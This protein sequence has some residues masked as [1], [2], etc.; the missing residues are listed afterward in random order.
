MGRG[1][2]DWGFSERKYRFRIRIQL[3]TGLQYIL[4]FVLVG[5]ILN[6]NVQAQTPINSLF[7][8]KD[9]HIS[10]VDSFKHDYHFLSEHVLRYF[11]GQLC[12][13]KFL[14]PIDCYLGIRSCSH[15]LLRILMI[16]ADFNIVRVL[17]HSQILILWLL[18]QDFKDSY[19]KWSE[20]DLVIVIVGGSV[21][22]SKVK[23]VC[24]R[25]EITE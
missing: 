6:L 25:Q 23:I 10:E 2:C 21:V 12:S 7:L 24:F 3:A 9:V 1:Y 14:D 11:P 18:N 5:G 20:L 8:V 19:I 4:I 13:F 16:D 15:E 17:I 22:F